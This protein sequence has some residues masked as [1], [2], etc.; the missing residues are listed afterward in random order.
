MVL[1][2]GCGIENA[3][4]VTASG[5]GIAKAVDFRIVDGQAHEKQLIKTIGCNLESTGKQNEILDSSQPQCEPG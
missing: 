1:T 5:T 2:I 3:L 4:N